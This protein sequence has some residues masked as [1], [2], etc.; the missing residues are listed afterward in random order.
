MKRRDHWERSSGVPTTEERHSL[1]ALGPWPS[2]RELPWARVEEWGCWTEEWWREKVEEGQR[3]W[4][5]TEACGW[6]EDGVESGIV[7]T[8]GILV[9]ED[10]LEEGELAGGKQEVV[11]NRRWWR[12]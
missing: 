1:R 12:G 2:D 7:E 5:G 9:E 8:G 10:V 11:A 4:G 3:G 6:V